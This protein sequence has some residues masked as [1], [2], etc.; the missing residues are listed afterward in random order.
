MSGRDG[1]HVTAWARESL[2]VRK[3]ERE[4]GHTLW[5]G[6]G[7]APHGDAPDRKQGEAGD[8]QW[9]GPLPTIAELYRWQLEPGNLKDDDVSS[10]IDRDD[11]DVIIDVAVSQGELGGRFACN[12]VVTM[13]PLGST[14]TPEPKPEGV[15]MVTIAGMF[16]SNTSVAVLCRST[17]EVLSEARAGLDVCKPAPKRR[18][19]KAMTRAW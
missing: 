8:H 7:E 3:R 6:T 12:D 17:T 13:T 5:R 16:L 14:S 4:S 19:V 1:H 18:T 15:R 10:C 9:K 11:L 2:A